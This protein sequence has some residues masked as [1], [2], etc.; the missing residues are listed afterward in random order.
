MQKK[1]K[2][3]CINLMTSLTGAAWYQIVHVV[4]KAAEDKGGFDLTLRQLDQTFRYDDQVEMPKAFEKSS[5][6]AAHVEKDKP[7]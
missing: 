1:D 6:T 3:A 7:S 4:D 2:E 5:S